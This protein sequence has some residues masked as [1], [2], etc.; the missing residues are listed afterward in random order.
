[1][2]LSW[3]WSVDAFFSLPGDS[4]RS[5][6]RRASS[7]ED[8]KNATWREWALLQTRCVPSEQEKKAL[9]GYEFMIRW[10]WREFSE[11]LSLISNT[12]SHCSWVVWQ[13]FLV[14][15]GHDQTRIR[16]ILMKTM[17]PSSIAQ[18]IPRIAKNARKHLKDMAE[19]RDAVLFE[20]QVSESFH[21]SINHQMHLLYGENLNQISQN[22]IWEEGLIALF[23]FRP[24][25][26]SWW[27]CGI[28][29]QTNGVP[30]HRFAGLRWMLWLLVWWE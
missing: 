4:C 20:D 25:D 22:K 12:V 10:F 21:W 5:S 6:S 13:F 23:C 9:E 1:M 11:D 19:I 14:W 17:V 24:N 2:M 27:F 26:Y 16:S 15:S 7:C 8:K 29:P 3:A 18:F 28:E 30:A